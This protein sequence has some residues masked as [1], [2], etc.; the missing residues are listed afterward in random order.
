MPKTDLDMLTK[1]ARW[2]HHPRTIDELAEHCGIGVPGVY[3]RLER[4]RS[5][6]HRITQERGKDGKFVFSVLI[7]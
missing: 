5:M 4:L 3:R 7:S 1:L 2:M 6:G